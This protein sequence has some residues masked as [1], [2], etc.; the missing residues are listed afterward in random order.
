MT[1]VTASLTRCRAFN[2]IATALLTMLVLVTPRTYAAES[3]ATPAGPEGPAQIAYIPAKVPAPVV[4][5][6]SGQTGP[7]NY[8]SYA[9]EIAALGYYAVLLDGKDILTRTQDG[10]GNL[11]KAIARA[12]ASPNALPGKAA[13]IGFSQG[14]GGALLHAA[15]MP[16]LVSLVVAYYPAT[17]WSQNLA[18]VVKRFRVPMLV[19]AGERDTYNN[20]CLIEHMRVMET[21]ARENA[22]PFELVAY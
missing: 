3:A 6:L 20:C 12:Q 11:Q 17:S 22:L 7:A 10:R 21:A 15:S 8:Q 9:A 19:L 14:G 2:G 4:I 18:G 1:N 13:V 16:E 5:L